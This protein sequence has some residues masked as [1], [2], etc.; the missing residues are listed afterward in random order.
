[1]RIFKNRWFNRWARNEGVTD[2][3]LRAAAAEVVAG[4]VEANLGGCLFK[5]RL[6]RTGGGK[7]G[8]YRTI[9]GYRRADSRRII[10]L[11]AFPKNAKVNITDKE[12]ASLSI[13][14]ESFLAATDQQISALLVDGAIFEVCDE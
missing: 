3:L 4:Q 12:E 8:G 14:A 1:M 9:I 2:A 13:S 10:F 11:F 7:S 6:A 5:K